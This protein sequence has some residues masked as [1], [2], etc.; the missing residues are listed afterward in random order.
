MFRNIVSFNG[1]IHI[2]TRVKNVFKA[3]KG[4]DAILL[5]NSNHLDASFFYFTG[6]H[7]GLFEFASVVMRPPDKIELITYELEKEAALGGDYKLTVHKSRDGLP[8]LL[9]SL[10]GCK[11]IAINAAELKLASFRR[12][13]KALPKVEWVDISKTLDQIRLVKDEEELELMR[14]ACQITS[15]VADDIPT[16]V[17]KGMTEK[18]LA[19][20]VTR[21]LLKRG[22]SNLAFFTIVCFGPNA[23][24]PH[25]FPDD[26]K[27]K[28]D[29]FIICDFGGAVG[30]YSSDIT[31]TFVFGKASDKMLKM[32][33]CVE[34]AQQAA[35]NTMKAGVNGRAVHKKVEA[36]LAKY[37]FKGKMPHST[38]HALGID[39]HDCSAR[40]HSEVDQPLKDGMVFT[41]EPGVYIPGLG[42][43]R[44][45][46]DVVVRKNGVEFLTDAK[47]DLIEIS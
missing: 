43:V 27:L 5:Q 21:E 12:I 32:Y 23:A 37:G 47:R 36:V 14:K 19:A 41:V 42:G 9:K 8:S 39:V 17:H 1:G 38:G 16:M 10:K 25:H 33:K 7:E 35:L 46:D 24:I 40:I 34:A 4:V 29:Q 22:S 18:E 30:K 45:E 11:K 15:R 3:V 20:E 6:I 13:E 31:R 28:K 2:K 44:I 26:S